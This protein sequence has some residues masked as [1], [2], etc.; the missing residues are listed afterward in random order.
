M[1]KIIRLTSIALVATGLAACS[2]GSQNKNSEGG[3]N[4]NGGP[5]IGGPA[6]GGGQRPAP[7]PK[8]KALIDETVPDFKQYTFIDEKN[9][10]LMYN[11]FTPKNMERERYIH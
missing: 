2:S 3:P 1:K 7:G 4:P 5:Q 6:M 9:D 8:L 10:T 11:L